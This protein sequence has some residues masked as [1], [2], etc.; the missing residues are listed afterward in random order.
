MRNSIE[1]VLLQCWKCAN[2]SA[3]RHLGRYDPWTMGTTIDLCHM[4]LKDD[5]TV[6]LALRD[7]LLECEMIPVELKPD[8]S[9]AKILFDLGIC[10]ANQGRYAEEEPVALELTTLGRETGK[11]VVELRGAVLAATVQAKLGKSILAEASL[12]RSIVLV[13]TMTGMGPKSPW[14]IQQLGRLEALLRAEGRDEDADIVKAEET[15]RLKQHDIDED[16]EGVV[17]ANSN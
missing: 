7:L 9:R 6:E 10:L 13:D 8:I 3:E 16:F 2:D 14:A 4:R 5:R 1:D 12:R 17:D 15:F 11:K